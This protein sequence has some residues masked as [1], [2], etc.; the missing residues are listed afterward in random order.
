MIQKKISHIP[1]IK[2]SYFLGIQFVLLSGLILCFV[3][4]KPIS[5]ERFFYGCLFS[6]AV[7]AFC[8][9]M[10]ISALNLSK[11]TGKLTILQL[12]YGISA[13]AISFFKYNESINYICVFG[14]TIMGLGL[15]KTIFSKSI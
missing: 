4:V 13:Y 12:C 1:G 7:M 15:Y 14:L 8:Q 10:F 2:I 3:D 11:N 9:I 6:G 5:I